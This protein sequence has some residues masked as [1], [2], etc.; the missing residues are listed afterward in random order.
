MSGYSQS[1]YVAGFDKTQHY[2]DVELRCFA[3]K[4]KLLRNKAEIF[5]EYLLQDHSFDSY[6][7][8]ETET[9]IALLQNVQFKVSKQL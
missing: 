2:S 6:I 7:V 9:Y 4:L 5:L 1:K 3:V 8:K